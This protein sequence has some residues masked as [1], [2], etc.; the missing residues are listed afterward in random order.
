MSDRTYSKAANTAFF[1]SG[2]LAVV[3]QLSNRIE[4]SLPGL[5]VMIAGCYLW[6]RSALKRVG[7]LRFWAVGVFISGLSGLMLGQERI[8]W[9]GIPVSPDGLEIGVMIVLRMATFVLLLMGISRKIRPE[10]IVRAFARIG[11]PQF[12]GAL[13]MATELLPDMLEAWR[14]RIR[15]GHPVPVREWPVQL[16]TDAANL[17]DRIALISARWITPGGDTKIFAVTGDKDAGKTSFL[18]DLVQQFKSTGTTVGGFIQ[19]KHFENGNFDGFDIEF[20]ADGRSMPIM[21]HKVGGKGWNF[22][23]KAFGVA[24][25]ELCRTGAPAVRFVDEI[26][27]AENDGGGHWPALVRSLTQHGG[28]WIM[29][30]RKDSLEV[31][32]DKLGYREAHVL[33]LP[34]DKTAR[35]AFIDDIIESMN[36]MGAGK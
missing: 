31:I 12:G 3:M 11:F 32:F 18:S 1:V 27:W 35:A 15:R 7:A 34:A 10:L 29:S 36:V 4:L 14:A 21:R 16:I 25:E 28:I 23:H 19:R 33:E 22:D 5:L 13:A 30:I 26:G 6:E 9:H 17:A 2:A 24:A 20:A 8:Y